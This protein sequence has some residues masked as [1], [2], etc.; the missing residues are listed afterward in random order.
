MPTHTEHEIEAVYPKQNLS[1]R[2]PATYTRPNL[3]RG[4][5]IVSRIRSGN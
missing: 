2:L 4:L 1:K 5:V 3:L